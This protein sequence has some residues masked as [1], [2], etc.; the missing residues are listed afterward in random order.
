MVQ[1]I[2][3]SSHPFTYKH[4]IKGILNLMQNS[5]KL[6]Y[7]QNEIEHNSSLRLSESSRKILSTILKNIS[8]QKSKHQIKNKFP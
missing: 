1:P 7:Q 8:P 3:H 2:F 5:I 6:N 4:K